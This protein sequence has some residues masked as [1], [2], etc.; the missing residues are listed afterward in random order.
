MF[1]PKLVYLSS[2]PAEFFKGS[3]C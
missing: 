3:C 1:L 2:A